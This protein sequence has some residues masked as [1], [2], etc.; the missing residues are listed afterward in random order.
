VALVEVTPASPSR[1]EPE[2]APTLKPRRPWLAAVLSLLAPGVGQI[3]NGAVARGGW[4]FCCFCC[5]SIFFAPLI[6]HLAA[7]AAFVA[8]LAISLFLLLLRIG[9]A[10][11]AFHRARS[12]RAVQIGRFQKAGVYILLILLTPI[13]WEILPVKN[14]ARSFWMPSGSM[15]PTLLIGDRFVVDQEAYQTALPRRGDI[16][17]FKLPS[18]PT[19]DYV[20]RIVALPGDKVQMVHGNL[21]INGQAV[22]RRPAGD[23]V[24]QDHGQATVMHKY[25]ESLPRGPDEPPLDYAILKIGDNGPLDNTAVYEVPQGQYFTLGDNR[26]NSQDSR[27]LSAVGYIPRANI[28][29]RP[30]FI[31]FSSDGTASWWEVWRWPSTIHYDR[32]M[33]RVD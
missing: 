2:A 5:L 12:I 16:V 1:R 25:I 7:E 18:D 33:R 15:L 20:K 27:V 30:T 24:Y 31:F 4:L 22:V 17:V 13:V 26:D 10:I 32:L 19:I 29:G 21:F 28:I 9:A 23:Y 3:Y 14:N 8:V 11:A 6:S